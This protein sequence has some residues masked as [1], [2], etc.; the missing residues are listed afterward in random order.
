MVTKEEFE[1]MWVNAQEKLKIVS[2]TGGNI[3][4]TSYDLIEG[5]SAEDA[6]VM[7]YLSGIFISE[8]KLSSIME[9]D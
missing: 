1:K 7:L 3:V 8:T 4:C 2:F 5:Q 9:V 6:K